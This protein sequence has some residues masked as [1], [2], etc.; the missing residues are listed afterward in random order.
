[1]AEITK[2]DNGLIIA[3]ENIPHVETVSTFISVETGSRNETQQNNGISHFLEHML[4]K[5]TKKRSA[6]EIAQEIDQIG[7]HMN[8]DTSRETTC[9]YIKGLKEHF[10]TSLDVLSDMYLNSI[11]DQKELDTERGVILQEI[12]ASKD[13]SQDVAFDL[14]METYC[15]N[16]QLGMS[17]LGPEKNIENFQKED[18]TNYIKNF[19]T[20]NN[21]VLS[22]CGNIKHEEVLQTAQ[23][24]LRLNN[25]S[26]SSNVNSKIIPQKSFISK[27]NKELKQMQFILGYEAPSYLDEDYYICKVARTILGSGMS[28][29][30]FQEIREKRGLVYTI[31]AE[32]SNFKDNGI[33]FVYA[34]SSSDKFQE[35]YNAIDAELYKLSEVVLDDEIEKCKNQFITS[36]AI[37]DEN[38]NSRARKLAY[39]ILKYGRPIST[40][41]TISKINAVSK[42]DIKRFMSN[43]LS[44]PKTVVT[45]GDKETHINF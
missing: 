17:I 32:V 45:Y 18:F 36:L 30:L 6:L 1:M 3:S 16:H 24:K 25:S 40:Q 22:V 13:D 19:Y 23:D 7:G 8:A 14:F 21:T 42:D 39:N 34:G 38:T 10:N 20:S 29:R 44:K 12:A 43:M 4:F 2:L 5:G 11:F 27:I 37:Q 41:E 33:F 9:Y 35:L 15:N 28:S 31:S 26:I